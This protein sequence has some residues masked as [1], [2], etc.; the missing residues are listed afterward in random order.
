VISGPARQGIA[1]GEFEELIEAIRVGAPYANVHTTG[2][3]G[4]EIRG[5]VV[6]R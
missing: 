2:R 1:A 5:L 4:G 3:L 6:V